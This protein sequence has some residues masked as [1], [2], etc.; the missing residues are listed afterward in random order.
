[1]RPVQKEEERCNQGK[2]MAGP[3]GHIWGLGES[4]F[5]RIK[6]C[7]V[8]G[9]GQAGS[10]EVGM[11]TKP[12]VAPNRETNKEVLQKKEEL[13]GSTTTLESIEQTKKK[14]FHLKTQP[15]LNT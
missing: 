4:G 3:A 9:V 7:T 15:R 13:G 8:A 1:M 14:E 11:Q 6:G 10:V 5:G 2:D 12:L